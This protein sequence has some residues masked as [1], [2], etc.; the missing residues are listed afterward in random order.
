MSDLYD[1]DLLL[2]SEHQADRLRRRAAGELVKDAELDWANIAEEIEALGKS[3]KRE[4]RNHIGTILAHLIKV[5]VSPAEEP[6][7]GWRVTVLEQRRGVAALLEDSPSLRQS[8]GRA[9]TAELPGARMEA[10]TSLAAYSEP[11]RLDPD[12][13][14]FTEEQVLGPWLP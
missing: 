2:W 6:R 12:T 13:L 9:M 10:R 3:D 1:T 5:L 4:L 14:A 8:V 7:I 11:L